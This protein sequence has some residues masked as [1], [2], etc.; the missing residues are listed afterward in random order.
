MKLP[1]RRSL[2][3]CGF[4]QLEDRTLPSTFGVP[5]ADPTRLTLSFAPDGTSTPVGA[6]NLSAVLGGVAA[7]AAWQRELLRAYQTWA[8]YANVNIG[9]VADGGQPLGTAGAPQGD[10]RFGDIRISAGPRG[11]DM[12]ASAMPFDWNATTYTGDL[13][14]NSDKHFSI[15]N[16]AGKYDL[17]SVALHEAGHS[18]G[19]DHLE[20]PHSVMEE[21]YEFRSGLH[22]VDIAAIRDMYG[23]RAK[24]SYDA[25]GSNDTRS[26]A[27]YLP[28]LLTNQVVALGDLSTTTDVDYYKLTFP[29]SVLGLGP[30]D[31]SVRLQTEGRSLLT[32][33]VSVLDANGSVVQSALTSNPLDNDV[34]LRVNGA[35]SGG[36]YYVKVERAVNDVF[37]VGSYRL[38]ADYLAA[39]AAAPPVADSGLGPLADGLNLGNDESTSFL[40]ALPLINQNNSDTP[41]HRFDGTFVGSI[42]TANDTDY[43]LFPGT[44]AGGLGKDS[45]NIMAWGLGANPITPRVHVYGPLGAPIAFSVL[46]NDTGMMSVRVP[47]VALGSIYFVRVSSQTPGATG[48][49]FVGADLND[50]VLDAPTGLASATLQPNATSTGALTISSAG[51]F[52]FN[53]GATL[54]TGGAAGVT[55]EVVNSAGATVAK[56]STV[57]NQL[58][59]TRTAYLNAGTYTVRYRSTSVASMP[60][61]SVRFDFYLS[62]LMEDMGPK[63]TSTSNGS[64]PPPP[65][66]PSYS[67]SS[68][69]PNSN[70]YYF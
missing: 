13:F 61:A 17:F 42:Q 56:F 3:G 43:F 39:G 19:V 55:M 58:L 52:Q 10:T 33:K 67:G 44:L 9:L 32:A 7:P 16:V 70:P 60:W 8:V 50:I 29:L 6:S 28:S 54:T 34:A 1:T 37:A 20:D 4:I 5:W 51:L 38:V 31:L 23:A 66:P 45:L 2:I 21:R 27:S 15:G 30:R 11:S 48:A 47:N 26:S 64:P 24:D 63:Q 12:I 57:G 35:K 69:T 65:P 41:D 53:L 36:T 68:S 49:Y 62:R 14:F 59:S 46:T 40:N 18:L 22:T 25:W